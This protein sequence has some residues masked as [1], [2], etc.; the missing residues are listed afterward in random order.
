MSINWDEILKSKKCFSKKQYLSAPVAV[1]FDQ[2]S[3]A[4]QWGAL[5]PSDVWMKKGDKRTKGDPD[6]LVYM[7]RRLFGVYWVLRKKS[8]LWSHVVIFEITFFSTSLQGHLVRFRKERSFLHVVS[9][10]RSWDVSRWWNKLHPDK[11]KKYWLTFDIF[12]C[13]VI[14]LNSSSLMFLILKFQVLEMLTQS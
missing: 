5:W 6:T 4:P 7:L 8:L 10:D 12:T 14:I 2:L 1:T 11:T 9:A 3:V 13:P